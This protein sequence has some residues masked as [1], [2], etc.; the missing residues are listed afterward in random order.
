VSIIH[1]DVCVFHRIVLEPIGEKGKGMSEGRKR[2]REEE[3][4]KERK[5]QEERRKRGGAQERK[6]QR[7]RGKDI[8][9]ELKLKDRG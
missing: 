4:K 7:Q 3:R 5:E 6:S 8:P 9:L 1:F 2:G